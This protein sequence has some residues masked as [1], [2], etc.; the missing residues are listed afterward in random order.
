MGLVCQIPMIK[1]CVQ[2]SMYGASV[3]DTNDKGL[4][5]KS[6]CLRLMWYMSMIKA[7]VQKFDVWG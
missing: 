7:C 3:P 5:A 6:L 4:C 2:K 1:A